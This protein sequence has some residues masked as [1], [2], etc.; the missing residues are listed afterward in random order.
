MNVTVEALAEAQLENEL[1]YCER[2]PDMEDLEPVGTE[3]LAKIASFP[4]CSGTRFK[5][6]SYYF[7][8]VIRV[9]VKFSPFRFVRRFNSTCNR[10]SYGSVRNPEN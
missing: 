7:C 4:E 2:V 10:S 5:G 9:S 6:D 1:I 8:K 3:S